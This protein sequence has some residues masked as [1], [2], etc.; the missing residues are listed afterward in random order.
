MKKVR[1]HTIIS[2]KVQG[3]YFRVKTKYTADINSVCGWVRNRNDGSVEAVFEGDEDNVKAVLGWCNHGPFLS[4]VKEVSV[5]FEETF[6]D[7][8]EFNI[9]Y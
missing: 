1:A 4:E 5:T 9:T 7:Y 8:N 2:G 6:Q 3:V